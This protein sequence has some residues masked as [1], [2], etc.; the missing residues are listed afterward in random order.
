MLHLQPQVYRVGRNTVFLQPEN[1]FALSTEHGL[2]LC[3]A[4]CSVAQESL[5]TRSRTG[6]NATFFLFGHFCLR[7]CTPG[8][9]PAPEEPLSCTLM[10]LRE[11]LKSMLCEETKV[12]TGLS[13]ARIVFTFCRF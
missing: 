1:S 8:A 11:P 13:C 3:S 10:A 2:N 5:A 6:Q 7:V 12:Q 4:G 9:Q